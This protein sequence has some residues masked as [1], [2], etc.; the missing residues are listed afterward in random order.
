M[1]ISGLLHRLLPR[2]DK[3]HDRHAQCRNK[4]RR[5]HQQ[6]VLVAKLG[7]L[8]IRRP[9]PPVPPR[10]PAP[11]AIRRIAN[12]PVFT[13][14]DPSLS[15]F[16]RFPAE[17]RIMIYRL[18]LV[19]KDGISYHICHSTQRLVLESCLC[20]RKYH[21]WV[22]HGLFPAI[23][24]CCH[25]TYREGAAI[26][27]GEN[28]FPVFCRANGPTLNSWPISSTRMSLITSVTIRTS[29][30]A[31]AL[32]H[33][34][35]L[36]SVRILVS[37]LSP[38]EWNGYLSQPLT[39][40]RRIIKVVFEIRLYASDPIDPGHTGRLWPVPVEDPHTQ[41][42]SEA[43]YLKPYQTS[44]EKQ[45][46]L[47]EHRIVRWEFASL[48]EYFGTVMVYL[49]CLAASRARSPHRGYISWLPI[50]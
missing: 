48:C 33:F 29:S 10:T 8:A 5:R 7:F 43:K 19:A 47:I 17:V 44:L 21:P 2:M 49:E 41:A 11:H 4:P 35:G 46:G 42:L 15:T 28:W 3:D 23:L 45:T 1:L 40:L 12:T 37:H 25:M 50:S 34:S 30:V 38:A 16:L 26:L 20:R 13:T 22:R 9:I 18:L 24:E 27:Y 14:S 31:K 6:A 36:R 39:C 32:K